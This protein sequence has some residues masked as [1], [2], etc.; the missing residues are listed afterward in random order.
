[1]AAHVD[2]LD[3]PERLSR[4]F[5]GSLFLHVSI[6]AVLLS[7][8]WV[9]NRTPE[10][11]GDKGGGGMGSVAV[12]TVASIKLPPKNGPTNPVA[13]D[14]ESL[15]PEAP[16]K[17][18]VQPKTKAPEPDAIPIKSRNARKRAMEA[19]ASTP[20]KWREKQTDAPNQVY[21]SGQAVSSPMYNIPG[22]GGVGLGNDSPLGTQF[23]WY[24]KILRDQ[25][26]S[27]WRTSD[28]DPRITSAPQVAVTFTLLRNG[29]L[30]PGSVKVSQSSRNAAL[31]LSAQRAI[32]D[33]APFQ[34]LPPQYAQNQ[35]VLELRFEL[36][37]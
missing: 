13:S 1:M 12:N 9:A 27:K 10:A 4:P 16:A 35:A 2:I 18:K 5:M 20:N 25:V 11:W 23:G 7:Y 32:L 34:P 17:K 33:A 36:K 15:A 29:S 31:D 3:Q 19:A 21:S 30:A 14:T 26:A 37:R 8:T 22:G 6:A 28:V 24:A